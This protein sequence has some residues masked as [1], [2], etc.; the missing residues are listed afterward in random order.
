MTVTFGNAEKQI[1]YEEMGTAFLG[2]MESEYKKI[3]Q[4]RAAEEQEEK[5]RKVSLLDI[6]SI[7]LQ[8][9]KI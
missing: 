2:L 3:E 7:F 1:S 5:L 4:A 8:G 9:R 6:M